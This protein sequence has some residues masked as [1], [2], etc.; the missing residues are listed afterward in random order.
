MQ[1]VRPGA[2][3]SLLQKGL[4]YSQVEQ[5]LSP[6]GTPVPCC[7]PFTLLGPHECLAPD[8]YQAQLKQKALAKLCLSRY[9]IKLLLGHQDQ[10]FCCAWKPGSDVVATGS[11]DG[12]CRIWTISPEQSGPE[13]CVVLDHLPI[14]EKRDVTTIE[15]NVLASNLV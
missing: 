12:T 11:G 3:I 9:A 2:L 15:W 6:D 7:A 5:H 8:Q 14:S 13:N 10:V 1:T 4:L